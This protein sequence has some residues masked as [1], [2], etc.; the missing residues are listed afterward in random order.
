MGR[1]KKKKKEAV[2][3]GARANTAP[4]APPPP[5]TS[6]VFRL[7]TPKSA[8]AWLALIAMVVVVLCGLENV[9][10]MLS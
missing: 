10:E 8:L 5:A 2:S 6:A 3:G 9:K 4:P 7:P 1:K